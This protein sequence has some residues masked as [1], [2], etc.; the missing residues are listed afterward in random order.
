MIRNDDN[1][2][3][4]NGDGK[5]KIKTIMLHEEIGC[6][7]SYCVKKNPTNDGKEMYPRKESKKYLH[8]TG[9][10]TSR[11]YDIFQQENIWSYS[12]FSNCS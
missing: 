3:Y 6:F 7:N 12:A 5:Y 10:Y 1:K 4:T 2:K 8:Y 11:I 9:R